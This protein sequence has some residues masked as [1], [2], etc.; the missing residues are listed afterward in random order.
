MQRMRQHRIM[1][2]RSE[3][4]VAST[5]VVVRDQ[6]GDVQCGEL[7]QIRFAGVARIADDQRIVCAECCTAAMIGI[8]SACSDPVPCVYALTMI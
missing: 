6:C 8:S 3:A 2:L 1:A 5:H 4:L 7:L